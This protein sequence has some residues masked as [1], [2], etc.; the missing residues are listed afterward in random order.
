MPK[1]LRSL[2]I[3]LCLPFLMAAQPSERRFTS[4]EYISR[5]KD[6]A[7][8]EML[9]FGIPASII[10]AQGIHESSSGNSDL[11][12]YANNHFGI[13]CHENWG[14]ETFSHDDDAADECFRKYE[15]PFESYVDH[16]LFLKNRPRYAFLFNYSR[17]DYKAWAKG[18]KAAG[19]ATNPKY[20]EIIIE[21]IERYGLHAFDTWE[22]I[23][24]NRTSLLYHEPLPQIK[25]EFKET[26][27]PAVAMSANDSLA[28]E[29]QPD[30]LEES[31]V[32][33]FTRVS[34]AHEEVYHK[35]KKGETLILIAEVFHVRLKK[36]CRLNHL[37]KTASLKEGDFILLRKRKRK[38]SKIR[39]QI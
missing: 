9:K 23:P 29:L 2:Y 27:L 32:Q 20:A 12:V 28:L 19:Y 36:L 16:S 21:I 15:S 10:L 3:L 26:S 38:H 18:L 5:F 25:N 14:G 1:L 33:V 13:K 24:V 7:I 37:E 39:I 6:Q 34:V 17:K 31:H 4:E 11:A 35:V 22:P 8:Q 30:S